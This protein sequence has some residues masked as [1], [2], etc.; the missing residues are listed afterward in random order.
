MTSE[1][2]SEKILCSWITHAEGSQLPR[3]EDTEA[4]SRNDPHGE[5]LKPLATSQ[6]QLASH[7]SE[8]PWKWVPSPPSLQMNAAPSLMTHRDWSQTYQ[9][10]LLPDT[11]S[12]HNM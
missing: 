3:C 5:E 7:V 4:A 1:A 2:R 8:P 6:F 10:K 9:A 12:I 11:Q